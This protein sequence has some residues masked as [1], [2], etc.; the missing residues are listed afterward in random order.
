MPAL[1]LAVAT[2]S[3]APPPAPAQDPA[4]EPAL[5]RVRFVGAEDGMPR[6]G[7]V[8][9]EDVPQG[10]A[11]PAP[12]NGFFVPEDPRVVRLRRSP[13]AWRSDPVGEVR[14]PRAL[15]HPRRLVFPAEPFSLADHGQRVD[16]DGVLLWPVHAREPIGVR[17]LD[18][19]GRPLARF[20]VAVHTG[21]RDI[22]VALTDDDGRAILGLP[23]DASARV[24]IAPVGWLGPLDGLPTVAPGRAGQRGT[25]L[26]L[27]PHGRVRVHACRGSLPVWTE[28]SRIGVRVAGRHEWVVSYALPTGTHGFGLELPFVA[29]GADLEVHT[30]M[31][32]GATLSVRGPAEAGGIVTVSVEVAWRPQVRFALAGPTDAG[33]HW[34]RFVTDTDSREVPAYRGLN[35][36]WQPGD[37]VV[38]RG[39]RLERVEFDACTPGNATTPPRSWIA[40]L[41]VHRPLTDGPLDLG[42]VTL[43][44]GPT[45]HGQVVD[46][47]GRPVPDATVVAGPSGER[48]VRALRTDA[49]GRFVWD[50][51]LPRDAAGAPRVLA[52]QARTPE[53]ASAIVAGAPDG[54][55]IVLR[56]V[57]PVPAR[58]GARDGQGTLRATIHAV[59]P[60]RR[61][62]L[63]GER[64]FG[65]PP[66]Q[67]RDDG[68][69]VELQFA[70]LQADRYALV[71]N[72]PVHRTRLV[73]AGLHVP[74][75][76]PCTDPRLSA[77]SLR[78]E[79]T[80][81]RV[82]V[83]DRDGVP[84]A[85]VRATWPGGIEQSDGTGTLRFATQDVSTP[86]RAT[87]EGNGV[88][89][90]EVAALS[91][92]LTVTMQPATTFQ[93]RLEGLPDDV[94]ASRLEVWV[95][96]EERARFLGPRAAFD[97]GGIATLATPQPGRYF[98]NLMV[99]RASN[100]WA[101]VAIR[102]EPL[103]I[104]DADVPPVV[105]VL[106]DGERAT[107]RERAR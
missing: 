80:V 89:P 35:D 13:R 11:T 3:L 12:R 101:T 34:L 58:P 1:V 25:D 52:A 38:L 94:S 64:G 66:A 21:G 68:E 42:T 91:D 92:G 59:P 73:C 84:I 95:R 47:D 105:W 82:R 20:P 46:R 41:P 49:E 98:V 60:G 44:P 104:G 37:T 69:T 8:V 71:V 56:L 26:V 97:E 9:H 27:P 88:R 63:R 54:S 102:K 61:W 48:P 4:A 87:F 33:R 103:V 36:G 17:A 75:D 107:L 86:L 19:A 23:K 31:P 53:F 62:L 22:A 55:P 100:S 106:D 50:L 81:L 7:V 77:L 96:H 78:E 39:T 6:P 24:W 67:S 74:G 43:R 85:G 10:S 30:A 40:T 32:D 28:V 14:L 29:L 72:D 93:V 83:V 18:A 15:V 90:C 99:R 79:A 57:D 2:L 70:R 51:P 5:V 16:D 45:L 65:A 76:G